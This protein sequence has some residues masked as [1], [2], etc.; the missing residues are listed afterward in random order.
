MF[1]SVVGEDESGKFVKE[2]EIV[3]FSDFVVA[4]I[5]AFE[6]IKSG[7]HVLDL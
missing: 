3:K 4:E 7:S 1:D 6:E 2:G 5:D